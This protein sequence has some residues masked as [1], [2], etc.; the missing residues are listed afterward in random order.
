MEQ[1]V[2]KEPN[3]G[4]WDNEF[5]SGIRIAAIINYL[6]KRTI[7]T[8]RQFKRDNFGLGGW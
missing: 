7:K 1:S 8:S 5:E 3:H 2:K 4:H 6:S